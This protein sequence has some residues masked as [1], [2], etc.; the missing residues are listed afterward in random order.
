MPDHDGRYLD[1]RYVG[2]L[3]YKAD[4][5]PTS[6]VKS[7]KKNPTT[8]V[9]ARTA[10]RSYLACYPF[11]HIWPASGSFLSW[12]LTSRAI[13]FSKTT[14]IAFWFL[15]LLST[16][17]NLH[18]IHPETPRSFRKLRMFYCLQNTPS[19]SL[20]TFKSKLRNVENVLWHPT[21]RISSTTSK[22]TTSPTSSR[23]RECSMTSSVRRIPSIASKIHHIT[24]A[25]YKNLQ[26][27]KN[28]L[29]PIYNALSTT[30]E[31]YHITASCKK[32]QKLDYSMIPDTQHT[33]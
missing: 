33:L 22:N 28:A 14:F 24:S 5:S 31:I 2:A 27:V 16:T 15:I 4:P 26:K 29:W 7:E 19:N 8:V 3:W 32:L 9:V 12:L 20:H 21:Q 6:I 18:R 11:H 17:F 25:S 30:F 10:S 1:G 23:T 13:I